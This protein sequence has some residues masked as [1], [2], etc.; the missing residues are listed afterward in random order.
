MDSKGSSQKGS[1]LLLLLVVSNLLLCQGVVSTP[2][3]PNGPGNCQVS[4][5]DL[6]DR[7]VMVSHYI[8]DLS[9][10][11]FNE[12]H[13]VL[14]SLI[15]GL[16]RS[17][18][19]PLYHLVTEVRGMKGAPDA[20]LSRAIEIEEEN[21]RLLEGMEMIFGQVI[22]G[23]KETEPYP[24]WSGLPSLQTKDEDARYSAFYNLLHCLRRDSS[25]IDTYLKLLNCRIIYNNNC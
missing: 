19:D 15:L 18:N 22:P 21:K 17:W 4:L 25:K 5:R 16:L 23:A 24:V 12:F 13:E 1:R 7:A 6:F 8:H 10:E 14:M 9:S 20:I 2:V 11:M 3:C